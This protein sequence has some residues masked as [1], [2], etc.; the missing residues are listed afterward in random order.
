MIFESANKFIKY[1]AFF[2][3]LVFKFINNFKLL[4]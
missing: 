1:Y 2:F 4:V 3:I